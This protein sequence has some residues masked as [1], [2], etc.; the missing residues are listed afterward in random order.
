MKEL[1]WIHEHMFKNEGTIAITSPFG[2]RVHPITGAQSNHSGTDFG[3]QRRKLKQYAVADG[4]VIF[5]RDHT[6]GSGWGT[7]V[8]VAYPSLGVI[9]Q[10]AH[11]DKRKVSD[12]DK[13]KKGDV[14]GTTGT[15]GQST[16]VHLHL[17]VCPIENWDKPFWEKGWKDP[18]KFVSTLLVEEPK[19]EP[20]PAP[21]EL[22]VGDAVIIRGR[23]NGSSY[24]TSNTAGGVGWTRYITRVFEGRPFPYRV[25]SKGDASGRHTTGFYKAN[26][27]EKVK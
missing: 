27:L 7:R 4:E 23:G 14:L 8:Y 26:A 18:M 11:L 6:D 19:P 1:K 5:A 9:M 10:H 22:K 17:G 20:K 12:G 15:T 24:G 2:P 21:T 25:G 13:V 3:T 16:G